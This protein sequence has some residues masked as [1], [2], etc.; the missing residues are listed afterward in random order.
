MFLPLDTHT[1][2]RPISSI[3]R[4]VWRSYFS[5]FYDLS[6]I[7]KVNIYERQNRRICSRVKLYEGLWRW[8]GASLA[9]E[10]VST[11]FGHVSF[12]LWRSAWSLWFLFQVMISL[13][14]CVMQK[15][16]LSCTSRRGVFEV[17]VSECARFRA[18]VR[19]TWRWFLCCW[20]RRV[21]GGLERCNLW[22]FGRLCVL[23]VSIWFLFYYIFYL[24]I[25]Y[26]FKKNF[27][28]YK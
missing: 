28:L 5:C 1:H 12:N 10:S 18:V 16:Y 15:C 9:G 2:I 11:Y 7:G 3:N 20:R 17:R 14:M 6:P 22:V 23:E 27:L 4:L 24:L 19:L 21:V 25:I 13:Y 26:V 8:R